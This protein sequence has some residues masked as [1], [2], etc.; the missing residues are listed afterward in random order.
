MPQARRAAR[1][2]KR[3]CVDTARRSESAHRLCTS[4]TT[5]LSEFEGRLENELNTREKLMSDHHDSLSLSRRSLLATAAALG[6]ASF[7]TPFAIP[8]F[9]QNNNQ[10]PIGTWPAGSQGDTVN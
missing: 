10:P 6:G 1:A 7:L 5:R 3:A 4:T 8:A 9:A 2:H